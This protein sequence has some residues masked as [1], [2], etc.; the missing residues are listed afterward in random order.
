MSGH[1]GAAVNAFVDGELDDVRRDEVLTHLAWCGACRVE[2]DALRRFK[3]TL[4]AA[5]P[6]VPMD[7]SARLMAV[8]SFPTAT[9]ETHPVRRR[10]HLD[11]H[12]RL[13]R[14]AVSGA[15]VVLGIGGAI[16][17]AGPPPR[18]PVAPVDP[19]NAGFV[20]DH[21]TTTREV[22]LTEV[23]VVPAAARTSQPSP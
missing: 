5:A 11:V 7:L 23:N 16:S 2:V 1:L 13:R 8:S 6:A 4:R 18:Q 10:R 22:P 9:I 3:D 14:G 17:L 19:T 12:P 20:S 15:F 21:W